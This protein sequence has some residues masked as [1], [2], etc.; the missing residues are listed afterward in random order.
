MKRAWRSA[1][2]PGQVARVA[3]IA[4]KALRSKPR[5]TARACFAH[6]AALCDIS[7]N[8]WGTL[9]GLGGGRT[10]D[11]DSYFSDHW[12]D[13]EDERFER[14]EQ[15]FVWNDAQFAL[16]EP[17]GI[18]AGERVL[19]V[20]S[21]PRPVRHR[22]GAGWLGESGSASTVSISTHASLRTPI[23]A[24]PTIARVN[25]HHIDDHRL[26]FADQS[27]RLRRCARTC[28]S[29]YPTCAPLWRRYISG[30]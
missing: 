26:P 7:A 14:Y 28:W 12:R 21:G 16:L 18:G 2:L 23:S 4:V 8:G 29:M 24:G 20:G 22:T 1:V 25:F 6:E 5:R 10:M 9:S 19:D 17:A 30:C 15:L 11:I 13:I 3:V 27:V